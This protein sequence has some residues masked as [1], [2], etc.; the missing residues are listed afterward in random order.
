[1]YSMCIRFDGVSTVSERLVSGL[2]KIVGAHPASSRVIEAEVLW[3]LERRV[4][5]LERQLREQQEA[6]Y[7]TPSF[8]RRELKGQVDSFKNKFEHNDQL[9]WLSKFYNQFILLLLLDILQFLAIV[10]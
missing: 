2:L 1:M 3:A 5:A 9:N 7:A 10:S 8:A 6:L 4:A